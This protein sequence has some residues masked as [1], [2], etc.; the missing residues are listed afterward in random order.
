[1]NSSEFKAIFDEVYLGMP[2]YALETITHYREGNGVDM[3]IFL[4]DEPVDKAERKDKRK[5]PTAILHTDKTTWYFAFRPRITEA[6]T[7]IVKTIIRHEFVHVFLI[8]AEKTHT[9][10]ARIIINEFE[11]HLKR[12]DSTYKLDTPTNKIERLTIFINKDWGSDEDKARKAG[13]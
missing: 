8:S 9:R 11:K 7:D 3:Q 13:Y 6:S 5:Y 10:K 4:A 1:M 12:T 2:D